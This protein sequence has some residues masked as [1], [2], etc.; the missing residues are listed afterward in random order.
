MLSRRAKQGFYDLAGPLMKA[1][2]W[3]HRRFPSARSGHDGKVKIQLGPGQR[4]YVDD[5]INVDANMFTGKCDIWADLRNKLPFTDR[6]VDAI[7]SHHV[8]EHLPDLE[9]HLTDVYRV[10][11]TGG[12]YSVG[13]PNGD[14]AIRKFIEQEYSWF[15]DWP[16]KYDSIGGRFVN[17]VFCRNEHLTL[18]TESFLQEVAQKSGFK[19]GVVMIPR[20]QSSLPDLFELCMA[21][22]HDEAPEAPRTLILE[23]VK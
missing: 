9:F 18:L 22:E 23:F 11:K 5:W 12:I 6:S 14:V 16:D 20:T 4:N 10:L 13:G 19:P 7:Y 17:F 21:K 3:R 8:I 15:G 1:N 2:G